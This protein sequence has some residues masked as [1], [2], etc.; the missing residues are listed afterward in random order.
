MACQTKPEVLNH[1]K[2]EGPDIAMKNINM[3]ITDSTL[4]KLR[5]VAT[6]QNQLNNGDRDFPDGIYL[7]FF[8]K[9]GK[10]TSTLKANK[11][12]YYSKE[13]YYKAEGD[14]HMNSI[15][16][17]D[18]L[19]TETLFWVPIEER[20]HTD[21]FVTITTGDEVLTGEGL[22]ANQDFSEYTITKSS[23]TMT[24]VKGE[25]S[26]VVQDTLEGDF[27]A[28]LIFEEDTT[29]LEE[30]EDQELLSE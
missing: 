13:D 7:E 26:S 27:D 3:L 22:E 16:S 18:N 20:I 28:D 17:G 8:T 2:Y 9:T 19:T 21:Q 4:V 6:T 11:G 29:V 23:G 5:L 10:I 14:V 1:E 30:E 24:L 25:K 12:Y 15:A